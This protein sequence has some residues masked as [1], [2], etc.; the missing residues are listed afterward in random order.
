MKTKYTGFDGNKYTA[1]YAS[2]NNIGGL[3]SLKITNSKSK[4]VSDK[5]TSKA[6]AINFF[7]QFNYQILTN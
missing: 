4:T 7:N 2:F 3:K 5:L 1:E 6:S